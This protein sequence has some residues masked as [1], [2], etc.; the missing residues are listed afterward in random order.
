MEDFSFD[1]FRY[2]LATPKQQTNSFPSKQKHDQQ[3]T[4][5]YLEN[6]MFSFR[7]DKNALNKLGKRKM[8]SSYDF[9][10]LNKL[11]P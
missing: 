9:P 11:N 2:I 6:M 1:F 10:A 7:V 5:A 3:D 8:G 4:A